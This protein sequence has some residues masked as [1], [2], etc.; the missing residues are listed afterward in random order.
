MGK[1]GG[2]CNLRRRLGFAGKNEK[3]LYLYSYISIRVHVFIFI[4]ECN[5]YEL[6]ITNADLP[7]G[8]DFP[9]S[10]PKAKVRF[11]ESARKD[12]RKSSEVRSMLQSFSL[13]ILPMVISKQVPWR[14]CSIFFLFQGHI[15]RKTRP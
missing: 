1:S 14:Y 2:L 4:K 7:P 8:P 15:I 6:L 13:E 5:H 12:W 11:Y 9:N 3:K 10:P